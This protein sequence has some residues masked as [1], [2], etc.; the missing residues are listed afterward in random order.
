[1]AGLVPIPVAGGKITFVTAA[2]IL[3]KVVYYLN[4]M[5]DVAIK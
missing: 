4:Y 5:R 1:M 2:C 3:F